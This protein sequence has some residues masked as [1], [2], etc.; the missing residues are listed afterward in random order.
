[1]QAERDLRHDHAEAER[2]EDLL[3]E[4]VLDRDAGDRLVAADRLLGAGEPWQARDLVALALRPVEQDPPDEIGLRIAEE[5][6]LPGED[7]D[8]PSV[9]KDHVDEAAVAPAERDPTRGVPM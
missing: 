1:L 6:H 2:A 9:A 3:V 5:G 8:R 7:T 4:C